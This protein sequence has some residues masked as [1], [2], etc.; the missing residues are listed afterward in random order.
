[1]SVRSVLE[2]VVH[3][4]SFRNIDLWFQGT[5]T[6]KVQI[7]SLAEGKIVYAHPF[8]HTESHRFSQDDL[9]GY[10]TNLIRAA[11]IDV[12]TSSFMSKSFELRYLEE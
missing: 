8:A 4:E 1:M 12:G 6:L 7:E 9:M 3:L 2:L 10:T 5:Y 11:S